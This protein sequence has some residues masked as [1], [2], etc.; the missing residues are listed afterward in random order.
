M[1]ERRF[2]ALGTASQVP[3][4]KRNHNGY[5]LRWDDEGF[6]FDPGEGTQ[7]Q[8]T[9]AGVSATDI[10]KICITHFHGDHCLGL[11]GILQRLSLDGV[12]RATEV[13]YPGSGQRFF[14]N[15][16][17]A[18][19]YQRRA[20]IVP[21]PITGPGQLFASPTLRLSTAR[22]QHSVESWGF[23]LV[24]PDSRRIN[25]AAVAELG[26]GGPL[27]GRLKAEGSLQHRGKTIQLDDVSTFK[28][29]GSFAFIM[30]TSLCPA[31]FELAAGVDVLVAESTYM[32]D[33]QQEARQ[34]G[35]MSTIDAATLARDAGA[36]LLVLTHFSQRYPE[37]TDFAAEATPI[38]PRTVALGD[39]DS[40]DI[41]SG[42][43]T[44][45]S[46]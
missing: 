40:I 13:F 29:G 26:I 30:D 23:R 7:R 2:T 8:A 44:R 17:D 15:L 4:R 45:C 39:G 27:V 9:L 12:K 22:L 1:S 21:R 31:A 24:E 18:S 32:A 28:R 43:L 37:A 5:F 33:H 38:H 6:L 25:S 3:T 20:T 16:Q 42:A 19:I 41:R 11:P 46:L 36:D 10:T 14:D 34:R 35:H